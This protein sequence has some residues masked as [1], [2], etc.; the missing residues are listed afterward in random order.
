MSAEFALPVKNLIR[1]WSRGTKLAKKF[2]K[3]ASTASAEEALEIAESVDEL[4]KSLER[5]SEAVADFYKQC[6][7]FYAES[8]AAILVED[9]KLFEVFRNTK[10]L[11]L[12]QK[13]FKASSRTFARILWTK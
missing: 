5:D 4:Q 3:T 12:P 8:F 7:K 9:S 11:T 2:G 1:T 10:V 13:P 6:L